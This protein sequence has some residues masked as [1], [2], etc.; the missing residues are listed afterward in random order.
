MAES[1]DK[2]LEPNLGKNEALELIEF[3]K[4]DREVAAVVQ[5]Q[6]IKTLKFSEEGFS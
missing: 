5:E 1:T 3:A 2:L 6:P 4:N